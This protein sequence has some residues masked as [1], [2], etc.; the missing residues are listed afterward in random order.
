MSR[1]SRDRRVDSQ[2]A[3]A[4]QLLRPE[5]DRHL[6]WWSW[7][8]A[9]CGAGVGFI[10][11]NIPGLMVGAFAGNRLGAIRDAKGRSVAA[12][13]T[14][15]GGNQKAEVCWSLACTL[16]ERLDLR[17]DFARARREGAQRGH[18][19]GSILIRRK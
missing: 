5:V 4:R 2:C 10:I 1:C 16:R 11:A 15:L 8:G 18:F 3:H 17:I 13:F 19:C 9:V 12:V 7:L 14:D 6:P